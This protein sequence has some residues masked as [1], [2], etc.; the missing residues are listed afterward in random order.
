MQQTPGTTSPLNGQRGG[1]LVFRMASLAFTLILAACGAQ[2]VHVKPG[3]SARMSLAQIPAVLPSVIP[4]APGETMTRTAGPRWEGPAHFDRGVPLPEQGE[5]DAS[6]VGELATRAG[7]H[8][9]A[10]AAFEDVVKRDPNSAQA[11]ERLVKLYERHGEPE[12]AAKA[13]KRLKI[14][15]LPNGTSA[16]GQTGDL[17][18][19]W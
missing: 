1:R 7:N 13:Y 2:L 18:G 3:Q 19:S 5:M 11:W 15:G 9:A 12:K 14:L 16:G 6:S 10:I 4:G 8:E 17:L